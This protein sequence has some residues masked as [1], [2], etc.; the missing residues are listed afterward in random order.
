LEYKGAALRTRDNPR[1]HHLEIRK[2][3]VANSLTM[4]Q[5]D[6]LVLVT[7]KS[8]NTQ[9]KSTKNTSKDI[10]A[11]DHAQKLNGKMFKILT[12]W[13]EGSPA[14]LFPSQE[15]AGDSMIQEARCF[16]RLH[17]ALN[18]SSH[19]FFCL[20]MLKGFYLT[21]KD[22]RSSQSCPRWM[23]LGMTFNGKCL[24]LKDISP[25]I[26]SGYSLSD[27]LEEHVDQKYFLSDTMLKNL[28]DNKIFLQRLTQTTSK[29]Q[30]E[31]TED[32][33]DSLYEQTSRIHKTEGISPT[34]PTASGGHHIPLICE[35]EG[36]L[37]PNVKDSRDFLPDGQKE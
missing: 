26:E 15:I 32:K 23:S 20:R 14:N 10:K 34:V 22:I 4:V 36:S 29:D 13:S 18:K 6:S 17:D 8:T 25:K 28:M 35:S 21:V 33:Q 24:T 2:D 7:P 19:A 5:K 12:S 3:N 30:A 31:D 9:Y 1:C 11:M 37:P 16:L 27:I